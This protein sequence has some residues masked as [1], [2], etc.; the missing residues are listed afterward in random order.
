L[1][2]HPHG[3]AEIAPVVF[4]V[5]ADPDIRILPDLGKRA[6]A[7]Q[8]LEGFIAGFV[9]IDLVVDDP[10]CMAQCDEQGIVGIREPLPAG[11]R[12]RRGML[13]VSCVDVWHESILEIWSN[14]KDSKRL[15][16]RKLATRRP[17]RLHNSPAPASRSCNRHA[18]AKP[19][20]LTGAAGG[21][22]RCFLES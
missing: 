2:A 18:A 6:T 13:A 10:N 3:G 7:G 11:I 4:R 15:L 19:E 14:P 16:H 20:R 22:R 9:A 8:R 21:C 5:E 12:T 17:M 1:A